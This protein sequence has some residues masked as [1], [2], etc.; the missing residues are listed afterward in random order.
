MNKHGVNFHNC[1]DMKD[2]IKVSSLTDMKY[3]YTY[4]G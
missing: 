1:Y 4:I 3:D 2:D